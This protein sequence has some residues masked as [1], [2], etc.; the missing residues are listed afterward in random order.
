MGADDPQPAASVDL[1]YLG[2]MRAAVGALI[3]L[4][5]TPALA[6][7]H[8][9]YLGDAAPLLGWPDGSWGLATLP[10]LAIQ[11]ACVVRTIAAVLFMAG[12]GTRA[13]GLVCGLAGYVVLSQSPFGFFFTIHLLYQAAI[14]LALGD[15][16]STFALRATPARSPVS[17]YWMLRWWVASIYLWAGIY[18]LR[19]DWL[20]GRGLEIL[21]H[22][23]AIDGWL[24][25]R[26]L[27]SPW[28]RALVAKG[29]ALFELTIGPLLLWSRTRRY[30]IVAAY[31][32]HLS[33]EI[34]AHPDL[35][36]WGMMSLLL[37]F[38]ADTGDSKRLVPVRPG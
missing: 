25:D 8:V 11:L 35:L 2:W 1:R 26:L 34:T 15:S 21:R 27:W 29:V 36:G 28:S 12:I 19:S 5:T 18:K 4:R 33:L 10:P 20:D 17:S 38:I 31:A 23:G 3:L 37:C 16:G 24:A 32:F 14:L 30:A 7:F 6:L 22:P 9:W 13:A